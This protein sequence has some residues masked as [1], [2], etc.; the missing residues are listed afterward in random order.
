MQR[1]PLSTTILAISLACAGLAVSRW[2][3]AAEFRGL[4]A[5]PSAGRLEKGHV[6]VK[7]PIPVDRNAV[8]RAT[9]QV[10][11]S[12]NES[13]TGVNKFVSGKFYDAQRMSDNIN[14]KA[15]RDARIRVLGIQGIQTLSQTLRPD[16]ANPGRTQVVSQV[17]VTANTQMA[18]NDPQFGFQRLDGTNEMIFEVVQGAKK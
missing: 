17:S 5:I 14:Q 12:W 18:F 1:S 10:F 8:E 9:R 16:P 2:I 3:D 6:R 15:P 7:E 13:G 11:A 4:N